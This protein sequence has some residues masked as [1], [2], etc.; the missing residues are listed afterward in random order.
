MD[1]VVFKGLDAMG[2]KTDLGR[3]WLAEHT[4]TR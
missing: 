3:A 2:V 1:E 4:R